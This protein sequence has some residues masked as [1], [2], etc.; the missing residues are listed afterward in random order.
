MMRLRLLMVL[1][2]CLVTIFMISC[3][4]H[5]VSEITYERCLKYEKEMLK[6]RVIFIEK[7]K[8]NVDIKINDLKNQVESFRKMMDVSFHGTSVYFYDYIGGVREAYFKFKIT[9]TEPIDGGSFKYSIID[10]STGKEI[11]SDACRFSQHIKD[12]YIGYWEI[13][14]RSKE[15]FGYQSVSDIKNRYKFNFTILTVYK[16]GTVQ[17]DSLSNDNTLTSIA[18]KTIMLKK[19][20]INLF[21]INTSH[22]S[23][24]ELSEDKLYETIIFNEY[25]EEWEEICKKINSEVFDYFNILYK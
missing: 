23:F 7:H 24:E 4:G 21:D 3:G 6:Q 22:I 19:H 18:Y 8:T 9:P 20:K 5:K 17:K 12:T 15:E 2:V 14:F 13:P 11:E 25:M 1:M 10:K 16:N